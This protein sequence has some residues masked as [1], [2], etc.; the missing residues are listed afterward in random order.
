MLYFI[1]IPVLFPVQ[2]YQ[3]SIRNTCYSVRFGFVIFYVTSKIN[4]LLYLHSNLLLTSFDSRLLSKKSDTLQRLPPWPDV[5]CGK[6]AFY[7]TSD[8]R[9]LSLSVTSLGPRARWA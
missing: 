7:A 6:F 4:Y 8:T 3:H 5:H 9:T 1:L 2:A